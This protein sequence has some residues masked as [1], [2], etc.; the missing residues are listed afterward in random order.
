MSDGRTIAIVGAGFSG[1]TVAVH[2]L[3][4]APASVERVFLVERA[5][6]QIGGVAYQTDSGSHTLNVPAGRMSAFE[7]DPDDFLR[8]VRLREPSLTGGSFVPRRLYGEYL[9]QTLAEA[10]RRSTLPLIRVA[11]EVVGLETRDSRVSLHLADGRELCADRVLL[12]IGNYPPSDPPCADVRL[13]ASVRYA[14]DPWAPDAL[15]LDRREDVLLLGTGLTMCD[16]AL[17][18]RHADHRVHVYA[19]SRRGLLPLPHRL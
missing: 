7:D 8:F 15:E 13:V 19:L 2:L 5:Q 17:A 6:R 18:L 14:R 12:A 4:A 16:I 3:R 9:A 1:T 11:G 10:R